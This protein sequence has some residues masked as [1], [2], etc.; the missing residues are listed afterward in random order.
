MKEGLLNDLSLEEITRNVLKECLADDPR[1]T[2]GIG[3]DNMTFLVV[4]LKH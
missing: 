2:Q 3:G 1:K 4:Q